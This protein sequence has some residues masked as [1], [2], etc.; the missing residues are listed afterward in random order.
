MS[1]QILGQGGFGTVTRGTYKGQDVAVKMLINQT[2]MDDSKMEF[3]REI[4]VMKSLHH[5]NIIQFVGASNVAGK[6]ALVTE[7]APFGSL[8][9]V[10]KSQLVPYNLKLTL[11]LEI[12]RAIQ[13]LHSNNIIHRDIKPLN[14]LV[15]SLE[16]KASV[17]VKLT[18]F[19]TSKFVSESTMTMTRNTG[20]VTYMAPETLG[21]KPRFNTSADLYSFA[22]LMWEVITN[23]SA[24]SAAEFGWNTEI[25][26][27]VKAGNRLPLPKDMDSRLARLISDCWAQDPATRP[28]ITL[29]IQQLSSLVYEH[30]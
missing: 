27:F 25:E 21:K 16:H 7:F 18:D 9:S 30:N 4:S 19:G 13:F 20:T 26:N 6:L 5:P 11:L 23:E 29:V 8:D 3:E 10:L 12:A 17:H 15:F 14:V 24:F 22:I 28:P 2:L 1:G